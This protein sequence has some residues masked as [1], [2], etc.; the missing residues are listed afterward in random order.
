MP[1]S[2]E[3]G[4]VRPE[5]VWDP[6]AQQQFRAVVCPNCA[7]TFAVER[8]VGQ[9]AACG[10]VVSV[11]QRYCNACRKRMD[12]AQEALDLPWRELT[13]KETAA[14]KAYYAK[15]GNKR[16]KAMERDGDKGIAH[17]SL[18]TADPAMERVAARMRELGPIVD[19]QKKAL[20]A[21]RAEVIRTTTDWPIDVDAVVEQIGRIVDDALGQMIEE[22]IDEDANE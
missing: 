12:A 18:P 1:T 2:A 9:C 15:I 19:R 11:N 21:I 17:R 20:R 16:R 6:I 3:G 4:F 5:I 22:G 10:A 14:V 13:D 8:E 7:W